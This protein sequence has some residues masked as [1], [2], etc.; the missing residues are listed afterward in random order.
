MQ[1]IL[2][3]LVLSVLGLIF[4]GAS[5][6]WLGG[7]IPNSPRTGD[8]INIHGWQ[9]DW[10]I[11]STSANPY[12]RARVARNG[13]LAMRKE[14][15]VY[16]A[17]LTDD[18]GARLKDACTY[19][20]TGGD[21]PAKWWSI[22]LYDADSRLPMNEDQHLSFD[23][24]KARSLSGGNDGRWSF[25]ISQ[26]PPASDTAAWVSSRA[27]S[28][29]DVMLRLYQPNTALLADPEAELEPPTI[30]QLSCTDGAS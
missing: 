27:A 21:F 4:G 6:V 23:Q 7:L 19:R 3:I 1:A 18:T 24:T 20:V 29:F 14:E 25:Q 17:T 5:A 30:E 15:A 28:S 11:G 13:L 22:T 9:S 12:V 8:T 26:E 16:F 10:S 2:K